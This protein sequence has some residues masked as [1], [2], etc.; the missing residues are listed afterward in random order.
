MSKRGMQQQQAKVTLAHHSAERRVLVPLAT[1]RIPWY[2]EASSRRRVDPV[3]YPRT[4]LPFVQ[5]WERNAAVLLCLT[6]SHYVKFS[7]SFRHSPSVLSIGLLDQL[8]SGRPSL[9]VAPYYTL[10]H[11]IQDTRSVWWKKRLFDAEI[12]APSLQV[13]RMTWYEVDSST[14]ESILRHATPAAASPRITLGTRGFKVSE[15]QCYPKKLFS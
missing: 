12:C 5:T 2:W 4:A 9:G 7:P 14:C 3:R 6:A 10:I 8:L 11:V 1:T 13:E 15:K